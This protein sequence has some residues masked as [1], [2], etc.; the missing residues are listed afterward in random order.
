MGVEA[1]GVGVY[2][3]RFVVFESTG[4]EEALVLSS[5]VS[6]GDRFAGV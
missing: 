5:E 6:G 1:G 4:H 3:L 2:E